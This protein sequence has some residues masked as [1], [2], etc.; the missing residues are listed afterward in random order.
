MVK[1]LSEITVSVP[2]RWILCV[3]YTAV[4]TVI[5]LV[6]SS[7]FENLPAIPYADKIAHFFMYGIYAV[8]IFWTLQAMDR[9]RSL[10]PL[11]V[12]LFCGLYGVAMELLQHFFQSGDRVF[13]LGDIVAN[14]AGTITFTLFAK[15]M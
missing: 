12:V 5:S 4:I 9:K 13:S 8:L 15:K 7:A 11:G 3:L 10:F 2:E 1:S 14:F 6:P